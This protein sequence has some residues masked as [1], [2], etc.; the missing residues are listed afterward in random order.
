M[1]NQ[2]EL[3]NLQSVGLKLC[4]SRLCVMVLVMK[5]I[6]MVMMTEGGSG[7][8]KQAERTR[9]K[10]GISHKPVLLLLLCSFFVFLEKKRKET[11]SERKY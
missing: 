6:M 1:D 11:K 4:L 9:K 8:D 10:I 5:M 3:R 7:C 2:P